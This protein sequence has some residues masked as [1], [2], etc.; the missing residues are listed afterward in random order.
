MK[1]F[2]WTD[3]PLEVLKSGLSRQAV[4]GDAFTIAR[5]HLDRGAV[6]PRHSHPQE[7]LTLV[8]SGR[9]VFRY[10]D[11]EAVAGEGDLLLTP[12]GVAHEVEALEPTVA[13]DFFAPRRQDW[14]D[15][16]D[17]YLR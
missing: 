12:S 10:P 1:S 4:H 2:R 14:I 8:L 11:T 9:I 3:F 17:S 16:D 7:Q 6:V 5:I 13:I 15:G